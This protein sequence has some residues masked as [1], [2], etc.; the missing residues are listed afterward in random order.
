[1]N[2]F[3]LPGIVDFLKKVAPFNTLGLGVLQDIVSKTEIAF[4]P[5]GEMLIRAGEHS[6]GHLFIIQT[7]CARVAIT[8][9]SNEEI[10]VDMRGEGELFGAFNMLRG[11]EARFNVCVEEDLI[12]FLI[13]IDVIQSILTN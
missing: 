2:E 6:P 5:R 13:P 11:H 8:Y 7:G 3:P 4:Y 12:A 10:L 9:E 1:M